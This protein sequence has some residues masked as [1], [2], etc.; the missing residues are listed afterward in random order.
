MQTHKFNSV[1]YPQG[2][3]TTHLKSTASIGESHK[4]GYNLPCNH[5]VDYRTWFRINQLH[6]AQTM[7][8]YAQT[9]PN[10]TLAST[11]FSTTQCAFD[12][13]ILYS[14]VALQAGHTSQL[15]PKAERR[16]PSR[17]ASYSRLRA[18][19]LWQD[20]VA[21]TLDHTRALS[22][23]LAFTRRER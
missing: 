4:C 8:P 20:N 1:D 9:R 12:N 23:C 14:A 15:A 22:G 6:S 21:Q 5:L 13:Q 11:G 16:A 2:C 3:R 19:W 17:G 7:L 10:T 18:C